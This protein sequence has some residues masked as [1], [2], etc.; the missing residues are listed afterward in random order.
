MMVLRVGVRLTDNADGV[1]SVC[2]D[3]MSRIDLL[4]EVNVPDIYFFMN[5]VLP[6]MRPEKKAEHFCSR[7][8]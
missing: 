5:T 8:F 6:L 2:V 1:Q 3:I 7:T 4:R